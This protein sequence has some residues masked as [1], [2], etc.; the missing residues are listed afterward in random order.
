[1][2]F[3]FST[4]SDDFFVNLSVQTTLDMPD[5][6]ETILHFCE[7]VQKQFPQM[8]AFYR[9][10]TGEYVLEGD[11]ESGTYQW[12]EIQSRRL[13]A[14]SFN[15]GEPSA[16]FRLHRWLLERSVYYLGMSGLDV[17]SLDVLI[18]FNL[19]FRGNRDAVV[20]QVL[21]DGSPM[22]ALAME[23]A[24]RT[25]ECE[26]TV[27]VALDED[28]YLQGRLWVETRSNSFQVRT[29][30]YDSEPISVYFAVRRY[31]DPGQ[32]IDLCESYQRQ[33]DLCENL[34]R[35][36]IVPQVVQPLAAAIAAGG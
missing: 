28:C 36:I 10:E 29:G 33:C 19:D 15:P 1:M 11:R 9:R 23:G 20:G 17:E 2:A 6:R 12:M 26:P 8:A 4:V 13:A 21:L 14:G 30:Q 22:A 7:A 31:P 16:A 32:V 35:R 5:G 34:A 3:D 18:G 27:V 24:G 25:V